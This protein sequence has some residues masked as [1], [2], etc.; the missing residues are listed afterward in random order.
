MKP[1]TIIFDV[2]ETMLDMSPLK[3][4]VNALLG[5]SEGFRIWF[6]ML[7]HY[8]LVDNCTA[9]YHDFT[10]IANATLDMAAKA[11]NKS[12][13]EKEKKEALSAIKELP[14]YPDVS[15]GLKL[16][17]QSGFKLATLTNSPITTLA[18]QL[19][20]A[21]IIEYFDATLSVDSVKKYKPSSKTYQW[22]AEQLSVKLNETMLVAAHG[23]DIA[24]ALQA[25]MQ[26]AFIERKG[27]SLYPLSPL[28]QIEGKDLVDVAKKILKLV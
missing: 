4:N 15:K 19:K 6:G 13:S 2:N 22:A 23:W 5:S 20:F 25:G 8:S 17:K 11:V 7:L 21:G 1:S 24:G 3:K 12:I 28:P 10:V 9:N 14:A 16:L 18:A 26:A 27:Q